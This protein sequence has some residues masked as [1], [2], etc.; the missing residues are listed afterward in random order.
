MENRVKR[1]GVVP[2]F[3]ATRELRLQ[4]YDKNMS[5]ANFLATLSFFIDRTPLLGSHLYFN[6]GVEN[7]HFRRN[8][9][10]KLSVFCRFV[11]KKESKLPR[12]FVHLRYL[13]TPKTTM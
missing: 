5:C 8:E 2:L 9:I 1:R 4:K 7:S 12:N 10:E 13:L 6:M 3:G 11:Q